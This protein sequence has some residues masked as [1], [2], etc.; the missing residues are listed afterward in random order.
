ML[1]SSVQSLQP[2]A[3]VDFL[4][5][6]I[7]LKDIYKRVLSQQIISE[8]VKAK[9][10]TVTADEIQAEADRQRHQRHLES[11]TATFSWLNEQLMTPEDW[12][13]GISD[14]LIAAKLA[15][16]LFGHEIEKYFVEHQLEFEQVLLYQLA[17]PYLQLAQELLYQIEENEIGF[18]EAAH[19]YDLDE[20]RRLQFGYAGKLYRWSFT[21]EI[22]AILLGANTGE[23]IGPVQA[24]QSYILLMVEEFI[25]ARLT[26]E[27]RQ[28][29]LDRLFQNWLDHELTLIAQ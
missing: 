28:I 20:Q 17:V 8:T 26:P 27:I 5:R 16:S 22:A 18:Y 7:I 14:R 29:I 10:I 4:K 6:E 9:G 11:A 19:L 3:I 23:V 12:E 1:C 21:P 15:E 24:E 2:E 13:A 25:P